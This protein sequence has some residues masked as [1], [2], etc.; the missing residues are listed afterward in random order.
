MCHQV[1]GHDVEEDTWRRWEGFPVP[2]RG[3]A[4]GIDRYDGEVELLTTRRH[5]L[6][7]LADVETGTII[8]ISLVHRTADAAA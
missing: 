7:D 5:P 6:S 3:G 2:D 1:G 8:R 4:I